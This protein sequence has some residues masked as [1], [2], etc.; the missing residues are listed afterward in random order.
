MQLPRLREWRNLRG[1]TQVELAQRA[2]ISPRAVAGYEAGESTKPHT[3]R[4]VAEALGVEIVDLLGADAAPRGAAVPHLVL[5]EMWEASE[6][7]RRRALAAATPE[8]RA[9]YVE[10]IDRARAN[11]RNGIED[12][13]N[14]LLPTRR[15]QLVEYA[16]RL[17]ELHNEASSYTL[18]ASVAVGAG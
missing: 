14:D 12:A 9:R 4:K 16:F 5:E 8:E 18:H 15:D 17:G 13:Q 11:A 1:F 7:A 6:A 10:E 2:G 3:A